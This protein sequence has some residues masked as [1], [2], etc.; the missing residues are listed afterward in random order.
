MNT[1]P[2]KQSG[3]N[4]LGNRL[5]ISIT[6]IVAGAFI[7]LEVMAA[8]GDINGS[9]WVAQFNKAKIAY[10]LASN[11]AQDVESQDTD[12]VLNE[13]KTH[14]PKPLHQRLAQVEVFD[15]Q[16][17]RLVNYTPDLFES[18]EKL[19]EPLP[20]K[21]E[22]LRESSR[23]NE[24]I[25]KVLGT[26]YWVSTPIVNQT[27]QK[28]VG[29]LLIRYDVGIIRDIAVDRIK[30]QLLIA[31]F[32]LVLF[33][34]VIVL[35]NRKML[36]IPIRRI[37]E[38]IVHL[39]QGDNTCQIPDQH[40]SDE[41]GA[42][43]KALEVLRVNA[44]EADNLREQ[45][46]AAE[47]SARKQREA[48]EAA[49]QARRE[50]EM[51][52]LESESLLSKERIE[53]AESLR[54]RIEQLMRAVDAASAGDFTQ[55]ISWPDQDDDLQR[56]AECLSRLFEQL[57]ASI[58]EIG[59]TANYLSNSAGQLSGLS[60][61]FSSVASDSVR[62]SVGATETSEN[63]SESVG[64]VVV[65]TE[66]MGK[67][68]KD[69]AQN[70]GEATKVAEQAVSLAQSAATN[71]QQLADSSAGIG[72]V[73]KVINSIAEQTNLL[74]LNATIEAARAGEAGKGFAV[75]ANEVKELAKE[76]AN[77]TEEIEHRV[78]SIQTDTGTAVSAITD[79]DQIVEKISQ[80]QEIIASAVKEQ[81]STTQEISDKITHVARGNKDI[82]HVITNI[83]DRTQ[84][85]VKSSAEVDTAAS[86]LKE[87]A[88]RLQSLVSRFRPDQL[89]QA[90]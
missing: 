85:S 44:E 3:L 13:L 83:T 82:N 19:S 49:E 59:D 45:H 15:R 65:S 72:N 23:S 34:A 73:I 87:L 26:D 84:Q 4:S 12:R 56:M 80:I 64:E 25:K 52:R 28:R 14:L 54:H 58:S 70:A 67:S 79:I 55:R 42:I 77:A 27:V 18:R 29:T 21:P 89:K 32:G 9:L 62:E 63:M 88:D 35:I 22:F 78:A 68:I 48:A 47:E 31:A 1:V 71:V 8:I 24:Q 61:S 74:A 46:L 16:G 51:S 76:T 50:A 30:K 53:Y 57:D 41:I 33:C 37:T 5:A 7:I 39:A 10:V 6:A 66:Q 38:T 90:A 11:M 40:R 86:Q 69:I 81:A 75:V 2:E 17:D 36:I 43:S 60:R 20:W